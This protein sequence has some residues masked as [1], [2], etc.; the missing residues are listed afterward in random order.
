MRGRAMERRGIH[1]GDVCK[2]EDDVERQGDHK[3]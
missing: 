2:D 3:R 1:S